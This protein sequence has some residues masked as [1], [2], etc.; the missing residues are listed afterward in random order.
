MAITIAKMGRSIKNLATVLSSACRAGR[1][2]RNVRLRID[3]GT[4]SGFLDSLDDDPIAR[5][6]ALFHKPT[7]VDPF[8]G[9][10]AVDDYFVICSNR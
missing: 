4:G 1:R 9:H 2:R 5:F 6:Q 7:I 3:D 10:N 8:A